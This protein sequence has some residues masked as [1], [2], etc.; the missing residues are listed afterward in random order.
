MSDAEAAKLYVT[1]QCGSA[2]SLGRQPMITRSSTTTARTLAAVRWLWARKNR[3][4]RSTA[5]RSR[6]PGSA[7]RSGWKSCS[8]ESASKVRSVASASTERATP[9]TFVQGLPAA[10]STGR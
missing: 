8:L 2:V 10:V 1:H 3:L 9:Y 6:I 5:L 7:T 4:A